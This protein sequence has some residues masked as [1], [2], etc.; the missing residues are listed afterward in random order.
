MSGGPTQN[1]SC[2]ARTLQIRTA[3]RL[4][5]GSE[6][7]T[8][9]GV[10]DGADRVDV[11]AEEEELADLLHDLLVVHVDLARL[12]D[13]LWDVLRVLYRRRYQVLKLGRNS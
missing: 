11:G 12:A 1:T 4:G 9:R 6:R 13:D 7:D 5:R 10:K 2:Q 8:H 3:D